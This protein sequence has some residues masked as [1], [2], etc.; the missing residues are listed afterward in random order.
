MG[1]TRE[2]QARDRLKNIRRTSQRALGTILCVGEQET[3]QGVLGPVAIVSSVG[4]GLGE[5]SAVAAVVSC[6]QPDIRIG[7]ESAATF[8]GNA[9]EGVVQRMEDE[10]RHSDLFDDAGCSGAVVVVFGAGEP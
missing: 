8:I 4:V 3:Q 9:D 10:R 2:P 5:K 7:F 1:Q 6:D